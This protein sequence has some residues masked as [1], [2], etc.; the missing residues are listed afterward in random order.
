MLVIIMAGLAFSFSTKRGGD[1][2]EIRLNHTLLLRQYVHLPLSTKMLNLGTANAADQLHISYSHCGMVGKGRSI[3]ARDVTNKMLRKWSFTDA[4][5]T[6][7]T[8]TIPVKD[9]LELEQKNG[10]KPMTLFYSSK[11]LPDGRNLAQLQVNKGAVA[12]QSPAETWPLLQA[13]VWRISW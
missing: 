11:E 6:T 13:A 7:G 4:T 1:M 9:L 5:G 2:Y 8:M 3:A 10:G 12:F